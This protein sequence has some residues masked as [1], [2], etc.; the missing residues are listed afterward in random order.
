[1]LV[2][3]VLCIYENNTYQIIEP[4]DSEGM[5]GIKKPYSFSKPFKVP[6]SK[7]V[8]YPRTFTHIVQKWIPEYDYTQ[9][10]SASTYVLEILSAILTPQF[11]NAPTSSGVYVAFWMDEND[12]LQVT[13]ILYNP[14]DSTLTESQRD[15]SYD[16]FVIHL[17][18]W[19]AL[20]DYIGDPTYRY[21]RFVPLNIG[22]TYCYLQHLIEAGYFTR[23][24]VEAIWKRDR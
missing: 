13:W 10:H 5:I 3:N 20:K 12:I 16:T 23:E 15:K 18:H 17:R 21:L 24:E 14:G 2:P 19:M 22:Y 9:I 4:L 7:L 1:L 11:L 6:L 8:E